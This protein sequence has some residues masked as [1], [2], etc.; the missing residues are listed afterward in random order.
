MGT[1][2]FL[3]MVL[4]CGLLSASDAKCES[5]CATDGDCTWKACKDC[6]ECKD[7]GNETPGKCDKWCADIKNDK[8]KCKKPGCSACDECLTL[9]SNPEPAEKKEKGK[10]CEAWCPDI[11]EFQKKCK[12]S[13]CSG[14]DECL[15]FKSN[16]DGSPAEKKEKG[17][18]CEAWCP[19]IKD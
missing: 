3:M 11:K 18:Y 6:S 14:C 9:K 8:K 5:W 2:Y 7:V 16:P 13:S 4:L 19:D 12:K 10:L 15:T 1:S 17:Q